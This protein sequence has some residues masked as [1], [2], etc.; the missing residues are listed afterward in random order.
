MPYQS[1][2][3]KVLQRIKPYTFSN[4]YALPW[5]PWKSYKYARW[6]KMQL[7]NI[8]NEHTLEIK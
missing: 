8:G 4:K 5:T 3:F 1:Y 6:A 7:V 2:E